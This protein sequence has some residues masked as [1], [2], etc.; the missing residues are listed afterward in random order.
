MFSGQ[1]HASTLR[2][3]GDGHRP[4]PVAM[5]RTAIAL[6]VWAAVASAPA[7]A[8]IDPENWTAFASDSFRLTSNAE[9]ETSRRILLDLE[10]FRRAFEQLAPGL[11]SSFPVPTEILAF[12]DADSYAPFKSGGDSANTRIL[13]QF[14][15]HRDG[16]YI[17]LNADPGLSGG[18]G[19]VLHEYVH[20]IVNQNLPGVP[21]WLNE[22]LAEYYSSFAVEGSHAVI[23]RAVQRHLGWWRRNHEVSVTEVLGED[24]GAPVHS[25]GDA[26][27]F[28]AV[29]WGLAH[30]LM[31]RP[32]GASLLASYL[33]AVSSG[34]NRADALLL[35]L[36]VSASELED[37]LRGYVAAE[38]MPAISLAVSD[39]GEVSIAEFRPAAADVLTL[40]GELAAR[41]GKERHA[42][43]LFDLAL[44]HDSET[45]EA[46][47]GLAGLRERH[48]RFEEAGLLYED[49]LRLGPR[50]ARSYLLHGRYL[51]GERERAATREPG[52]AEKLVRRAHE[53]FSAAAVLDPGFAETQVALA[54]L[55]LYDGF[56]AREGLA[57]IER[58][59]RLL[60]TRADVVHTEIRLHLKAGSIDRADELL[61]GS[62]AVLADPER[63]ARVRDEIR[64]AE[65]LLSA[66][67]AISEGRWDEGLD[68]F[69]RAIAYTESADVRLQMEQQLER[70]GAEAR[71]RAQ[72]EDGR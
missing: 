52:A 16:N 44:A 43:E 12:R 63:T 32:E 23:G 38:S 46:L 72:R 62:F 1:D 26:G 59:R 45:P 40:L 29:S 39:L 35:L 5:G 60:P 65:L 56:E 64:R 68:L 19:I 27:R 53:L 11:D 42:E 36:D 15:G 54:H 69:D 67:A 20:H 18:L 31:S 61:A 37:L 50:A 25:L 13:G 57:F 24:A 2:P 55:H 51:L 71:I 14:L 30:Y 70:L 47:V 41:L 21:R 66:R 49:A 17:T 33:E 7:S 10:L 22:G 48:G 6:L 28:Y 34:A 4:L 8:R 9:V 58:A 3:R